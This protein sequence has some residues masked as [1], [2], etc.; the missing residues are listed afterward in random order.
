MD[1]LRDSHRGTWEE[2][3]I[4]TPGKEASGAAG[5]ACPSPGPLLSKAPNCGICCDNMHTLIHGLRLK[6]HLSSP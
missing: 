1:T 5:P 3:G 4:H 2:D 6:S